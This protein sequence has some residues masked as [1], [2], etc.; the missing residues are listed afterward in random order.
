[1]VRYSTKKRID[2][3]FLNIISGKREKK[4]SVKELLTSVKKRT[5]KKTGWFSLHLRILNNLTPVE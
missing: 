3:E 4:K 1:M 5:V 2:Q